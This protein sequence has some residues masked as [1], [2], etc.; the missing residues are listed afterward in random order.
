MPAERQDEIPSISWSTNI[1]I[2]ILRT[3]RRLEAY[4]SDP[5]AGRIQAAKEAQDLAELGSALNGCT[6]QARKN[7]LHGRDNPVES[8]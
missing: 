6:P 7:I 8:R 4:G 5:P 3:M 1:K 2:S